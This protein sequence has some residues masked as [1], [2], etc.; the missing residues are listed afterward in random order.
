VALHLAGCSLP[1][2]LRALG[3]ATWACSIDHGG[4]MLQARFYCTST[5]A[6]L[7]WGI[8]QDVRAMCLRGLHVCLS[9]G[10][11]SRGRGDV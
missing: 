7:G 11:V 5:L 9:G 6:S 2:G 10:C 3:T 4:L 1:G 8:A